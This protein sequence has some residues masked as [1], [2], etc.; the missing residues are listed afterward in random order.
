MISGNVPSEAL[1]PIPNSRRARA[2]ALLLV[3]N[4][5]F[6][7]WWKQGMPIPLPQRV[8][9]PRWVAPARPH[10]PSEQE[11]IVGQICRDIASTAG[12]AKTG[13]GPER[14][15]AK[16]R[17]I[18]EQPE[19]YRVEMQLGR[20]EMPLVWVD[21]NNYLWDPD[22]FVPLA[23]QLLGI[24]DPA[25]LAPR[26]A[27]DREMFERLVRPTPDVL[28][29]ED[30]RLSDALTQHPLDP[31]LHEEAA[32]LIAS[33]ALRHAGNCFYDVRRELSSIT[34]HLTV[35]RTL[36]KNASPAGELAEAILSTLC[37]RQTAALEIL[38]RLDRNRDTNAGLPLQANTIWSRALTMRTTG[39]Y[40]KLDQPE[41]ASLLERLEYVRALR[42]S[43][44]SESASNFLT[45]FPA[46]RLAEWSNVILA[47]GFSVSDGHLWAERALVGELDETAMQYRAYRS[48]RL[49]DV[50]VALNAPA[51]QINEADGQ[52]PR[53]EVLGW[54]M[55]AQLHQRQLCEILRATWYWLDDLLGVPDEA[56]DFKAT[57]TKQFSQLE[58]FPLLGLE[59]EK[60]HADSAK[61]DK[62]LAKLWQEKPELVPFS[63]VPGKSRLNRAAAKITPS[64]LTWFIPTFP[65]GTLYDVTFRGEYA[66]PSSDRNKIEQFKTMAPYNNRV[67]YWHMVHTRPP[68][69]RPDP[70]QAAAEFEA[71]TGFD[72]WSMEVVA[73]GV[74]SDPDRYEAIFTRLCQ[75][76][77][78]QYLQLGSYLSEH[79]RPEAA[80]R[81]Y[82]KAIKLAPDRVRVS[83]SVGWLVDYYYTHNRKTDA[84]AVAEMAAD[85]YSARG[86]NTMADLCERAGRLFDAES[87]FQK[88]AERYEEWEDLGLFYTRHP[89]EPKFAREFERIMAKVF[90]K[91]Q[92]RADF[93]A[94]NGMPADGVVLTSANPTIAELSLQP[95]DVIVA[96]NGVR[97][98]NKGQYFYKMDSTPSAKVEFIVWSK[99][100][101]CSV[102]ADLPKHRLG[103]TIQNFEPPP[104]R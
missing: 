36:D 65:L 25:T 96:I 44:S 3:L 81:A 37:G 90:P 97:I 89:K 84:F 102:I 79:N 66:F 94:L 52:P 82:E 18:G 72:A 46:E 59:S 40:R 10:F 27:A 64:V 34:A 62:R 35:A 42:Y 13:K 47:G 30:K 2:L 101:Y 28:M 53:M 45:Q 41:H 56:K 11:W 19:H 80:V 91:G 51:N 69:A 74:L 7:V 100:A 21:L 85:A 68:G 71:L 58:R 5:L 92:E 14:L 63:F 57:I 9:A 16:L 67:A 29:R 78:N 31:Q 70:N 98:R 1:H 43:L 87:Y 38:Q 73:N 50:A 24:P 22:N 12:F 75:I 23:R 76:N 49:D 88:K 55:W 95:G 32:L 26:S 86:L 4:G 39:D 93:T 83:N 6:V 17:A 8:V 61:N 104:T 54:G 60:D 77:P 15:R 99:R 103:V 20:T 48:T 33:F